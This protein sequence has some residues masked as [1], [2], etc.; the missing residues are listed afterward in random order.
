[1][2]VGMRVIKSVFFLAAAALLAPS[3]PEDEI[4]GLI[5]QNNEEPSAFEM[6][7]A[8]GRTVADLGSF[9]LRQPGVCETAQYLAVRLEAKAKFSVRLI[10]D[11][12]NE[13]SS[14]TGGVP[15]PA[16]ADGADS[17]VTGSVIR[18]AS[19]ETGQSS[20]STLKLEDMIPEWRGPV[21]VKKS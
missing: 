11:W 17:L 8:A 10:Y 13:A 4:A 6:M 15:R 18:V 20:Q 9:C 5:A 2:G 21:P 7:S 19:A 14:G 3:P 12:A 16:Q 1:M